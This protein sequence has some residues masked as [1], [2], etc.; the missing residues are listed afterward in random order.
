MRALI[1]WL[2]IDRMFQIFRWRLVSALVVTMIVANIALL[3]LRIYIDYRLEAPELADFDPQEKI[4]L[5]NTVPLYT[6]E[7]VDGELRMARVE[8]LF[9]GHANNIAAPQETFEEARHCLAQAIYFEARSE[10]H[11]GWEAVAQVVI[12]RARD[13]RYPAR[14]CDVVFQGE[15]RRHRCQFSFACDGRSD[16]PYNKTYWQQAMVLSEKMLTKGVSSDV[17]NEIAGRATHY[18]ADYVEPKWSFALVPI[19]KIGRHIFYREEP[20]GVAPSP[21]QRPEKDS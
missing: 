18:H 4:S 15:Y 8:S 5:V 9:N 6:P 12:N 3:G 1:Q 17:V 11:E 10:P 19:R 20:G 2:E 21:R 7:K 13:E 14:I 16:Q